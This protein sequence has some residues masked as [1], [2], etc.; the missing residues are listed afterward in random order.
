MNEVKQTQELID[1]IINFVE[2]TPWKSDYKADLQ[3]LRDLVERPC[4]LAIAGEV[5]AGKSSFF[6]ALLGVDLAKVGVTETTAT[7]NFF[8]YGNPADPNK[9]V[10]VYWND[11]REPEEQTKDF[12]DSLQGYDEEV[13]A[14][15]EK[16][17]HLEYLIPNKNLKEITIIDTP[18]FGSVEEAHEKE[19]A[20][21]LRPRRNALRKRH[22]EQSDN[23]TNSADAVILLTDK[24]A[25]AD[26]KKFFTDYIPHI[27][28]SNALGVLSKIDKQD[29]QAIQGLV[30]SLFEDL[31]DK[32]FDVMPVSAGVYHAINKLRANADLLSSLQEKIKRIE[33]ERLDTIGS[34]HWTAGEGPYNNMFEQVAGLP[35]SERKAMLESVSVPWGVFY[36]IL[37][38]L[39]NNT[40]V[41]EAIEELIR[42]SGMEEVKSVLEKQFFSRARAIRCGSILRQVKDILSRIKLTAIPLQY[43]SYSSREVYIEMID[44]AKDYFG[45]QM[46]GSFKRFVEQNI[47]DKAVIDRYEEE[48]DSLLKET[49]Q[50]LEVMNK[51]ERQSEALRLLDRFTNSFNDNE[52]LEIRTLFGQNTGKNISEYDCNARSRFWNGKLLMAIDNDYRTLLNYVCSA[53]SDLITVIKKYEYEQK[54]KLRKARKWL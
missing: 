39:Y 20:D 22:A 53:Y 27:S 47:P 19:T 8:R 42:Y 29:P 30:S 3:R 14:R 1:K 18:G 26:T 50:L 5:K 23:F 44:Y 15:A 11:G 34:D 21:F 51:S 28:S 4:D 46:A 24:P 49:N 2:H 36:S 16:I 9:P 12:L 43:S 13:L 32:L 6:N 45:E 41:E 35:L 7:I 48:T 25:K 52:L 40:S 38:A 37:R 17:D 10:M 33:E 54:R 31:Q